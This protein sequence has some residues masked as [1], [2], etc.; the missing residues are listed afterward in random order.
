MKDFGF[1]GTIG[2]AGLL[3]LASAGLAHAQVYTDVAW[4]GPGYAMALADDAYDGTV[5]S[6][7]CVELEILDYQDGVI[8]TDAVWM[9]LGMDH[10]WVGD[11][12][13][14]VVSPWGTVL[15][16]MNRPGYTETADDG[17]GCCGYSANLVTTDL[18]Y[19]YDPAMYDAEEMGSMEVTVCQEA[20]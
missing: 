16:V 4:V 1:L 6:M 5:D 14:K 19:F 8:R 12:V 20:G 17:A 3:V 9:V 2:L 11:L 13:F 10:T 18:V 15:T 7:D